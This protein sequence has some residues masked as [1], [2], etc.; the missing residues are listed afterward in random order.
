MRIASSIVLSDTEQAELEALAAAAAGNPRLAQRARMIL[1]AAAGWQ[2]KNIAAQMGIGR[3]QVARWRDRYAASRLAGIEHDLP[4]GAPPVR[5]DVARL[6]ALARAGDAGGLS[7]R[8][9]AAELGVSSASVSRHWRASGLP[10]RKGWTPPGG[11][12]DTCVVN[13]VRVAEIV[14]VYVAPPEHV[15]VA[16]LAP[17]A[18]GSPVPVGIFPSARSSATYRRTLAASFMTALKVLDG[19][20]VVA[21][22]LGTRS[23]GWLEFLRAL[24]DRVPAGRPLLLL[25]DNPV[26]HDHPEVHDIVSGQRWT[27]SFAAGHS[28]WLRTVQGLLRNNG[29]GLPAGIAQVLAAVGEHP[30][31]PFSWLGGATHASA[32]TTPAVPAGT[33]VALADSPEVPAPALQAAAGRFLSMVSA[34]PG[35]PARALQPVA[36][37]KLLPPRQARKLL[38]RERLM[39]RLLDARRQRCV[40]IQGQAGAGKTSTLMAWR[41][42]LLSLGFDVSWLALS[43]EDNEPTRCFDCLVASLAGADAAIARDAARLTGSAEDDDAIEQWVIAVVQALSQREREL[44]LMIDDLHHITDA[45]IFRALQ[46]L[47]DYA[48]PQLHLAL[49]SRSALP[50]ALEPLRA[51]GSLTEIDMRDLR[52]SAEESERFLCEQLGTISPRDAAAL[53]ALTDGWVAGLQLFSVDLRARQGGDYPLTQVRDPRAF[54]A[55]FE[56]EVLGRLAPEDLA[57]LTRMA[58]CQSFCA[59]LCAAM[60][61]EHETPAR[62]AQRLARLEADNLFITQTGRDDREIWYR[63]H[64]LLRE[65]LL[66]R[67]EKDAAGVPD[68]AAAHGPRTAL[69]H[70]HAAARCWFERHG[71]LD[72]AVYHAVRAGEADAAAQMVEACGHAMLKRGELPQLLSLMRRLPDAQIH[73]RFGLLALVC[74]LQLYMRNVEALAENLVRLEALC[75]QTDAAQPYILCLLRAGR[76][77]QLDDPDTVVRM[78]PILWTI[79]PQ[80]D[81]LWWAA[82]C[83]VLSWL[84]ILR[85]EYDEARRLQEDTERRSSAPRSALFGR[86]ITAMSLVMEGEIERAGKHAREVLREADRQ[87]PTYL[88]LT[89]M[90]AGL[91][92]DILYELNDPEG[93]CQLLEPRIGMLER[94]SLPDVVLR[95]LTLLSNAHWLA[96][97]TAQAAA[98]LDRLEAYAVRYGLD[99]LLAEALT[100]RLRRHLQLAEMDRASTILQCVQQ[101]AE[102]HAIAAGTVS[103]KIRLAAVRAEI[104]M[105]L[106]MQDY[107]GAAAQLEGL[108]AQQTGGKPLRTAALWMQLAL[109]RHALDNLH[110]AR[111][112]FHAALRAGHQAGLIR[113]L[114]DATAS[115]PQSFAALAATAVEEP[116]LSFYARRL[117]LAPGAA[118]APGAAPA[119]GATPFAALSEREREIL[120]LLAL[121]MSNKK[122]ASVLNVSPETVKWHLKNIYAKLGVNGRGRAAARLRD[123]AAQQPGN[124]PAAA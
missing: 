64:P 68:P 27:V 28:A 78:L 23:A 112:A 71:H 116:V 86:Y 70:L 106:S 58:A 100:V 88:G 45:R 38:P 117:Q 7:T 4:R 114:L 84:F 37:D 103:G 69:Q 21:R 79:P 99:R 19:D 31:G 121:A 62:I 98:C 15:I 72:D 105:A 53:H 56:R 113:T 73:C 5:T 2:N 18:S 122:I 65:T 104:E 41:K 94:V 46:W 123:L 75:D 51:Q 83:N 101:L 108:L 20:E 33:P 9:L 63:L 49:S 43:A 97:R 50:L 111:T 96:G 8:K 30:G 34:Q 109:A 25:A 40:V 85:G 89:C 59:D 6:V 124:I 90:A 55:Y 32:G 92:A 48:P 61:G 74:F 115:L 42:T 22:S 44:V 107:T 3:V 110:G 13:P 54:A 82:R 11:L 102:R 80:A 60:P 87:G 16:A 24:E 66:G 77:V 120:G 118:S 10:P 95:A 1:L 26:S 35:L 39:A 12:P 67:L 17:P 52:F 29:E 76:A 81:D 47:L 119:G 91:L 93:A 36:S 57:L 14:G